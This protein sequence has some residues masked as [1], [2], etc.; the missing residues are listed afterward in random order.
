MIDTSADIPSEN[1]SV[2]FLKADGS[3]R[4]SMWQESG[5]LGAEVDLRDLV[6]LI[7]RT[8]ELAHLLAN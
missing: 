7:R 5:Y 2:I 3:A 6:A 8:P 4:L 1:G